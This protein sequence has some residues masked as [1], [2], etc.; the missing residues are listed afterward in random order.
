VEEILRVARD[1]GKSVNE[2]GLDYL[3]FDQISNS[4]THTILQTVG[5]HTHYSHLTDADLAGLDEGIGNLRLS[6][7]AP[8]MAANLLDGRGPD[9][10]PSRAGIT[11]RTGD[12][13]DRALDGADPIGDVAG[14]VIGGAVNAVGELS[15]GWPRV[16]RSSSGEREGRFPNS[17]P[18]TSPE[19][20]AGS[21]KVSAGSSRRWSARSSTRFPA[22]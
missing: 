18:A 21:W 11:G 3:Y 14:S 12:E 20:R 22:G 17:R 5:S 16:P 10:Y 13:I 19:G 9:P 4:V 6:L 7:M 8:G 15:G 2:L 1:A